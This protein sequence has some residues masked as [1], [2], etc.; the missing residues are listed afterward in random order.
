MIN[1]VNQLKL[2]HLYLRAGFGLNISEFNKLFGI[3]LKRCISD[4]FEN[5]NNYSDLKAGSVTD[6][7]AYK[8]RDSDSKKFTKEERKILIKES[9]NY[10]RDMNTEWIYK[11]AEDRAQLREKMTL[12]WHGH[13]ACR[14]PVAVFAKNQNNTIRKNALG[15]FGDLLREISKDPAMLQFLNN[16]QN[17]K[18]S[19]NENF[20][21][22]LMELFTM[23]RGNYSEKEIKEA[24]RA[25]TGWGFDREGKFKNRIRFHDNGE[26]TF[27]GETGNFDG[28][29][30]INMILENRRTSEFITEKIFKY[31]VNENSDKEKIRELSEKFYDS[32]YDIY[33]LM[34]NIFTS[35]WFYDKE[36][37]GIKIKS[38]VEFL[39][40]LIRIFKIEFSNPT[41]LVAVQKILGQMLF[42]PPNVAGW[43]GGRSWIDTSSLMYRLKFPGIIF[44]SPEASLDHRYNINDTSDADETDMKMQKNFSGRFKA[45]SD[46]KGFT[47]AFSRY[48][49][50]E[51]FDRLT[52]FLLQTEISSGTK[53]IVMKYADESEKKY[54]A[55][56]MTIRILS[57]P[58]YQM[59]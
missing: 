19:P 35:D 55:E 23:G 54:S 9:R 40:G 5:S 45:T 27:M 16:Q 28:D 24:A 21:R 58:E 12:F 4:I 13:F 53:S 44:G 39:A 29:D 49:R 59:C 7:S 37:I 6:L 52:E 51:L 10:I 43:P 31:F 50:D 22:E 48:D 46:I 2:K 17:R 15:K 1:P 26:K 47:E 32:E 33:S 18:S 42:N 56:S 57:L 25:F 38:P 41:A 14:T 30:I 3:S 11:M 36:N 20:A 34:K 8:L